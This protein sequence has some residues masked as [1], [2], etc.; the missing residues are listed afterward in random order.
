MLEKLAIIIE[1]YW[2][3]KVYYRLC[4]IGL[5][6]FAKVSVDDCVLTVV[7]REFYYP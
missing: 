1:Q 2:L 7:V 3:I 4:P 6:L 5:Q